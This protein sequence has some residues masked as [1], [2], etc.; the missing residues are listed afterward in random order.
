MGR[1]PTNNPRQIPSKACGCPACTIKF[2]PGTRPTT[3]DCIGSWQY[4]YTGPNGRP[5]SLNRATYEQAVADGEKAR[6]EIRAGTWIDPKRSDLTLEQ[7]WIKWEPN[8]RGGPGRIRNL[9]GYWRNH[10]QPRFGRT[11]LRAITYLEVQTWVNSLRGHLDPSTVRSVLGLLSKLLKA[12]LLDGRVSA[13][14]C[15]GVELP[16]PKKRSP[17][18][19]RPPSYAQLWLIRQQL[20]AHYH[21][22]QIL[23]QETGM[24][25]GELT[26]LRACWVDLEHRQVKVREVLALS[27]DGYTLYRKECPKSEAGYRTVPLSGLACRVLRDHLAIRQPA[28]TRSGTSDGMHPEELV[29][30]ARRQKLRGVPHLTPVS[31]KTF[32]ATWHR[33]CEAA[34]V[35]RVTVKKR[36]GRPYREFWPTWHSQRH[37]FASRL[38]DRGV[39]EAVTQEILGHERAG[40]VTWL[41]T[42]AAADVAG[43]VQAAMDDWKQRSRGRLRLVS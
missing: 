14:V 18:D 4:R 2:R 8:L 15:A 24:R 43:Q 35:L 38:H 39:P 21:A 12:A 6:V 19:R 32:N 5:R 37:A 9:R 25:W 41:Y 40:A 22:L 10:I 3:R 34:G 33:A 29:F 11:A 17:E 36:K 23:A 20:P 7:W 16:S 42:H 13:N 1:R 28:A 31:V 27:D 30:V 26:G